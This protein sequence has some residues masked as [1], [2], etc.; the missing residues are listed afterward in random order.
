L[1][2]MFNDDTRCTQGVSREV[3]RSVLEIYQ[4]YVAHASALWLHAMACHQLCCCW[5]R[6]LVS[7]FCLS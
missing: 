1:T 4:R 2:S 5:C 3:R 7:R 6:C